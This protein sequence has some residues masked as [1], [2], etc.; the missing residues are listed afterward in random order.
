MSHSLPPNLV[1]A[2]TGDYRIPIM[3]IF[4]QAWHGVKGMKKTFWGG[5]ALLFLTLFIVCVLLRIGTFLYFD[6]YSLSM[7]TS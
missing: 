6:Y 7:Y 5:F 1:K 3:S 2:S 4:R